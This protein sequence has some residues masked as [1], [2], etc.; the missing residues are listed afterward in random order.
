MTLWM[1]LV[2]PKDHILKVSCQ[3]LYYLL[4]YRLNKENRP[5]VIMPTHPKLTQVPRV[6]L[7][8]MDDVFLPLGRYLE[9]FVLISLWEVCQEGGTWKNLTVPDQRCGRQGHP[10]PS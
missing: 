7:D 2:D 10:L 1:Y 9:R 5:I 8:V 4:R 6:I 3:H